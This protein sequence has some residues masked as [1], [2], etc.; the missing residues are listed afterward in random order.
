ML[1]T[2]FASVAMLASLLGGDVLAQKLAPRKPLTVLISIDGF[3]PDYLKRGITPNLSRLARSG[4]IAEGM[5]PTFPSVT[6]PN[7]ISLVTGVVPDQHG[8]VNNIMNDPTIPNKRFRL[9]DRDA[10]SDPKWWTE[11]R[12][13]WVTAHRQKKISST[14]F[15][16][17]SD[18][19]IGGLQPDDWLPYQEIP[20]QER[21]AR[22]LQWL[23]RPDAARAD[24][25]TLYF[26]EV[27][28]LGHQTGTNSSNTNAAISNV[29]AAIGDFVAG[30]ERLHLKG[31]ANLV[32]VSDHGMANTSPEKVIAL[33]DLLPGFPPGDMI[34]TGPFA[35]LEVDLTK[36]EATLVALKKEQN[37]SCWR[38]SDIPAKFQFGSHRRIPEVFCLAKSGWTIVN[39]PNAPIIAGLHGYDPDEPDMRALFI[40]AGPK[41]KVRKT[42]LFKNT[43]VYPLLC[44]L[45]GIKPEK[46]NASARLSRL[47][48]R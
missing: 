21:V 25:A 45:I 48:I 4:S 7:H 37:M 2:I 38:K 15:W 42:G 33:S 35:G 47:L 16:P 3:R 18:V 39:N 9:S 17:G 8:I 32:I 29:D 31:V 19:L 14:L 23:D 22:L 40:A 44:R 30:L 10:L 46:T 12:P 34:W 28:V 20:S 27:D 6:F 11:V 13:I 41:I 36:A 5:I 1:K 43:E 26:S 24:F